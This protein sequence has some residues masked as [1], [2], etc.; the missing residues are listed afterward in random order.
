MKTSLLAA[1]VCLLLLLS[2]PSAFALDLLLED[3]GDGVID[4][5]NI[6][7]S[8]D[9]V[10][11]T[12]TGGEGGS[13]LL[14]Q[15][16]EASGTGWGIGFTLDFEDVELTDSDVLL[17]EYDAFCDAATNSQELYKVSVIVNGEGELGAG[18]LELI[19]VSHSK[20]GTGEFVGTT[21]GQVAAGGNSANA[22]YVGLANWDTTDGVS[23]EE[24]DEVYRIR[25]AFRIGTFGDEL[26]T[27]VEH[28][29][30]NSTGLVTSADVD[31]GQPRPTLLTGIG[32]NMLRPLDLGRV[33][34]FADNAE[35]D[36]ATI[37]FKSV[38]VALLSNTDINLD[39]VTDAADR[40]IVSDNLGME[41][42]ML[43]DGD[44]DNDGDV[45]EDDLSMFS[46][47]RGDYNNNGQIDLGD[48]DILAARV[49]FRRQ[50]SA[51]RPDR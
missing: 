49:G 7:L 43:F 27:N 17:V 30:L 20:A 14:R 45:D 21:W 12:R 44:V 26:F 8:G 9:A 42:A 47:L 13:A 2:V 16:A 46:V 51:I 50:S 22:K 1:A 41:Q 35:E 48:I 19:N 25:A 31:L 32:T 34:D 3:F 15:L 24:L 38:R 18:A 29:L 36:N 10:L 28:L 11:G 4:D 39:G 33:N 37:G 23:P 6:V 40:Q 5:P